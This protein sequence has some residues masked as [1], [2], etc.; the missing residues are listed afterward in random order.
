MRLKGLYTILVILWV[1]Y[2]GFSQKLNL[3]KYSFKEG[4]IQSTV[5]QIEEDNYGNLWLA[6]N[7][8]LSKFNGKT[9]SHYTTVN[10]L[11]SNEVSSLLF[12][13]D[14]VYIGTK[15]G[16]CAYNGNNIDN[17]P[18]Y[19][20]IR[21]DVKKILH[22]KGTLHV[23]TSKGYYALKIDQKKLVLDSIPIPHIIAKNPTDAEFDEDGNLW[24][25]TSKKGLFFIQ[26]TI[27]TK[28]PRFLLVQNAAASTNINN[29]MVRTV[30]FNSSN[31]LKSDYIY[32]IEFDKHKNLLVSDWG[33]GIAYLKFDFINSSGFFADYI[34][35]GSYTNNIDVKRFVNIQLDESGSLY[36]ASD[37]FGLFKVPIDRNT[38]ENDFSKNSVL[39]LTT[40]TGFFGDNPLCFKQDKYKNL[41]IGTLYDG[42]IKLSNK[43]SWSYD[44]NAGLEEKRIISVFKSSD[45]SIW[46]GTHAGGAF[47]FKDDVFTRCFWEQGISESIITSITE[48]EFGNIWLG[49]VGGGISII[50]K[51]DIGT[52]RKVS[53]IINSTNGL[54]YDYVSYVYKARDGSIWVGYSGQDKIDRIKMTKDFGFTIKPFTINNSVTFNTSC[55]I[56][57]DDGNIWVTS[58]EGVWVLN[59]ETEQ[60]DNRYTRFKNIQTLSKDWNGNMWLGSSDAG[61]IILKNKLPTRYF[62]TTTDANNPEKVSVENG[63]SSNRINTILF[64]KDVAWFISNNGINEINIDSY[65]NKITSINVYNNDQEF[66]SYDNRPNTA[67]MDNGQVIWIGSVEGLNQ[68]RNLN[69]NERANVTKNIPV[70]I[71]S[72]LIEN[73]PVDWT[74]DALFNQKEFT[75]IKFDGFFNWYKVPKQLALGYNRSTIKFLINTDNIADQDQITYSHK[76]VGYDKDW[77]NSKSNE[78]SYVS[79]PPGDYSLKIKASLNNDFS[80]AKEITYDFTVT[81]PFWKTKAFYISSIIII[82]IFLYFFITSREKRLKKEKM[83]LELEV[84]A[85]TYEIETKKKEIELQNSLIQGINN[86]LTDSIKYAQRIQQTILPDTENLTNYF[87]DHFIFYKPRNIVSGDYYWMKEINNLIYLAVVDCTG[88]GVPG[89]F[90]SLITSSILNESIDPNITKHKPVKMLRYLRKEINERLNKN[91]GEHINDGVDIALICY[92]KEQQTIEYVNANRPL[93]LISNDELITIPSEK[94]T[95]GGY[96][97]FVSM[98]PSKIISV[99]PGDLLFMFTDGITDQFGGAKN[100]KYNPSRLREFFLTNRQLGF[101][102]LK[103]K[104]AK[105]L[106]D[107]QGTYEQTDDILLVGIRI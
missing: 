20:K 53:K 83:K 19:R 38:N 84:K 49:T 103:E 60:V 25:A 91:H 2:S 7:D 42:V 45:G 50:K 59:P 105:E 34:S 63:I 37:G 77:E 82:I 16:F 33:N 39:W 67:V 78:I 24:I 31:L 40:K 76:L 1:F 72:I 8:G 32:C 62:E 26:T 64:A 100:K 35:F 74:N 104:L 12:V 11:P 106:S 81:P 56:D 98:I 23:L 79:L 22:K 29:Q 36:F 15:K 30:N 68:Y 46:C 57:D 13:N 80:N 99:K 41:W 73:K 14:V 87:A 9:F 10:G 44:K 5:K 101:S 17:H 61:V 95:I 90:M 51:E 47:R 6:T 107:W 58:N 85:R 94:V 54:F 69:E 97:D 89:A 93:Y 27:S 102:E 52:T 88:H 92:N 70:F 3:Q 86:D 96:A 48:D 18:L 28:L 4:L 66:A 55:I 75:S 21:G 43:S 71:N 65:L